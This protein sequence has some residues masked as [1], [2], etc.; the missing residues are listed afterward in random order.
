LE[1]SLEGVENDDTVEL[2]AT[3]AEI[4]QTPKRGFPWIDACRAGKDRYRMSARIAADVADG[5]AH[6][7]EC[8][9]LHRDVKPSNILVDR[10]GTARLTDFGLARMYGSSTLTATGAVLG[11][12]RYAS[13]EQLGGSTGA[14]DQRSDV[15]SLGVTLWEM[16]T[17]SRLYLADDRHSV[18]SHVLHE[19]V[20][21]PSAYARDIPRDLETIIN[22]AVAKLPEDRYGSA[23]AVADD[24]RRFLAGRPIEAKPL[25]L[26][27]RVFRWAN[28]NRLRVSAA[29]AALAV[30]A[31]VGI[32]A[33]A[34]ILSANARTAAALRASR[35]NEE[36]ARRNAATAAANARE[37][38]AL[39][40]A[41]DMGAAGA[42]WR[43]GEP[44]QVRMI[45]DRYREPANRDDGLPPEDPRG[46]EWNLLDRQT[47]TPSQLLFEND[48]ALYTIQFIDGGKQFLTTGQDAIVRWH[49]TSTGRVLRSLDTSQREV[50]DA[51]FNRSGTLLV[52]AGDDGTAKVWN[53]SDLSLKHALA[54]HDDICY[55]ARFLGDTMQ[56]VTGGRGRAHRV[57]DAETGK[58]IREYSFPKS[59]Q[60]RTV[61]G[62]WDAFV[63]RDGE[64]F[65]T[66]EHCE[67]PRLFDGIYEWNVATGESQRIS[68]DHD[69]CHVLFD[70]AHKHLILNTPG[71]E[72]RILDA[73]THEEV[74]SLQL[75]NRLEA[76][77][78]S[79]DQ[80]RLAVSDHGGQIYTWKL[81]PESR[82]LV[83][84]PR[85]ET[86]S[87]HKSV[88]FDLAFSPDGK[89]LLTAGRDGSVRRIFLELTQELY[90]EVP[91][92]ADRFCRP[93]PQ[94]NL[95]VT[96]QP[97]AVRES[98]TGRLVSTLSPN[99]FTDLAVSSDGTLIGAASGT[100]VG[101]WN[102]ATGQ[103]LRQSKLNR[104]WAKCL[105]FS[106]DGRYLALDTQDETN[107]RIDVLEIATGKME[108]YSPPDSWARW[109][110]FAVQDGLVAFLSDPGNFITCWS[111]P[112]KT[113]RWQTEPFSGRY[114]AA[115]I[116]PDRSR[117]LAGGGTRVLTMFDCS[118]GEILDTILCEFPFHTVAFM[119]DGRS[120]VVGGVHGEL[121][122]WDAR[123]G[124][125]LFEIANLGAR[126]EMIVPVDQGFLAATR[127][128]RENR[129]QLVWYEF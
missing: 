85:P 41:S 14:V 127:E 18:I 43:K 28:R 54:A 102:R 7:H 11:T 8:G 51:A 60:P 97:L 24:L 99:D 21:R 2:E 45:L 76:L 100:E 31:V 112:Q 19:E 69:P 40:Y 23:Q 95:V 92:L 109:A 65:W 98:A 48:E 49:D 91:W 86:H 61:P 29:V 83:V 15:Y 129:P 119:E 70:E 63:S 5:L 27:E 117:L 123:S 121:A 107:E 16:V 4:D 30:I 111:V 35:H 26:A 101:V 25:S 42:A 37:T 10:S 126:I 33:T 114:G 108:R 44:G 75:A 68:R 17:G 1:T 56:V 89:S 110:Y 9:V 78:L 64:R 77:A 125:H 88:V 72:V 59:K 62:S 47:R 79:P 55:F 58:L 106:P 6:A 36:R 53:V 84:S 122:I 124:K 20:S 113:I 120:F 67:Q 93:V 103:R 22:R 32:V 105:D 87:V 74:F 66:T 96:T 80:Q 71:G 128:H 104:R 81:D 57:F 3:Q 116:S 73:T 34:L 94:T 50:N 90:H 82:H 39:L 13:P 118:N 12:L 115:T 52:T 46:I 38:R